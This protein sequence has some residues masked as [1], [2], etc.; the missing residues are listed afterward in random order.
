MMMDGRH[1]KDTF[2]PRF[3]RRH[4]Q[5]DRSRLNYEDSAY[6]NK[7]DG[8]VNKQSDSADEAA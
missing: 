7:R 8:L 5:N 1:F 3:E 6:Q 2:A 4:L